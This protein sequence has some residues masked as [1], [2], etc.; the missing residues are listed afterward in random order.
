MTLNAEAE[1]HPAKPDRL[2]W[3]IALL[4]HIRKEAQAEQ[5]RMIS[6]QDKRADEA[7]AK[8]GWPED[9]DLMTTSDEIARSDALSDIERG[10]DLVEDGLDRLSEAE[11]KGTGRDI[12]DELIPLL[13]M[14]LPE[15]LAC[16]P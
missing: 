4:D 5:V 10:C 14:S 6:E 2:V 3:W 12:P 7:A 15:L 8:R 1:L 9:E 16:A 11:L 13:M